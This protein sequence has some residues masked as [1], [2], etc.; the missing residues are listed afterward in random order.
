[1]CFRFLCIADIL[2]NYIQDSLLSIC[3][4]NRN[5]TLMVGKVGYIV[6]M[7]ALLVGFL[8]GSVLKVYLDGVV[9]KKGRLQVLDLK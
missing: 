6:Y 4:Y 9:K 8:G 2:W 7:V 3:L 5:Y 1:M